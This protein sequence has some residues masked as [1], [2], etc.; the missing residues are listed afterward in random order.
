M[1][2]DKSFMQKAIDL[3]TDS[4]KSGGYA[5][6]SVIV[7]DGQVIATGNTTL[8]GN[9]DP[10]L[11]GEINAIRSACKV[12]NNKYLEGCI[13]YTTHEPCPMCTSAAIWAKMKG[14]VFGAT[15]EDGIAANHNT[16][17]YR[18]INLKAK[19][20]ADKGTPKVEIFEGFMREECK[21]LF[22]L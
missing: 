20:V 10:T 1:K 3:A 5:I 13:L 14:I 6:G 11:H 22:A 4:A 16:L 2:P 15:I 21:Q 12:L 8:I 9:I 19:D 17:S 7:K 18:Q